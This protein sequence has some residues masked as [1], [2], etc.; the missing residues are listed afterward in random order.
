MDSYSKHPPGIVISRH[1]ELNSMQ[2]GG[3]FSPLAHTEEFSDRWKVSKRPW[4]LPAAAAAP[5]AALPGV[6]LTQTLPLEQNS[7]CPHATRETKMGQHL[8][9]RQFLPETELGES[10]GCPQTRLSTSSIPVLP[11]L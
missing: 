2:N 11:A 1:S 9:Y 3:L 4:A 5:R 6:Q 7:F 10:M 8:C